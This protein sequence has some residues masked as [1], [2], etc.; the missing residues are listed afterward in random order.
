MNCKSVLIISLIVT[1]LGS[2]VVQAA[3]ATTTF[4]VTATVLPTC[5]VVATPLVFGNYDPASAVALDAINTVTVSCAVGTSYDIGL[6]A[7]IGT[8]ATVGSRKMVSGAN[9][10]NY[11]LYQETGHTTVWGNTVASD[12]VNATALITPTVHS[13]YGRISSGQFVPAGAYTDTINVTVTY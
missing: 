7:G 4:T 5:L 6:N 1:S 3:T 12:T 11:T 10:L 9:L 13:V 2:S 8:L